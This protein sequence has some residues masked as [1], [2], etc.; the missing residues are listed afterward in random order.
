MPERSAMSSR[1]A[2]PSLRLSTHSNA[3]S[4]SGDDDGAAG[5]PVEAAA[6]ELRLA[7]GAQVDH[8]AVGLEHVD[9]REAGLDGLLERGGRDP[10]ERVR[11]G[12]VAVEL[13]VRRAHQRADRQVEPRRAELA[14]VA[15]PRLPVEHPVRLAGV[16]QH[17]R[18]GTVDVG[19]AAPAALV[20][21][22]AVVADAGDGQPVHDPVQRVPVA[23]AA[24]SAGRSCRGRTRSGTCGAAAAARAPSPASSATAI[25]DRLSLASDG[26]QT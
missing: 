4:S 3:R 5:R 10:V 18:D 12:V 24:T 26:W 7:V 16:A 8:R 25:P 19:V 22:A 13:A 6:A 23:R 11:R 14:L 21:Q 2:P 17:G 9:D 20:R 15:A 1:L